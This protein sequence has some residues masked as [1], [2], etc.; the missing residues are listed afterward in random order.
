MLAMDAELSRAK[1][2]TQAGT[3]KATP[4]VSLGNNIQNKGKQRAD[5]GDIA[6][7]AMDAELQ[8]ALQ[9]SSDD[10][11]DQDEKT[12]I[13]YTLIKNFLESFK[14][15]QGLPGPVGNLVGRLGWQLP[16]DES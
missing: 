9:D 8:A 11:E 7:A 5:E 16:R 15:Q 4:N 2:D 6:R 1:R 10:D 12:P 3:S 13:D 14:S